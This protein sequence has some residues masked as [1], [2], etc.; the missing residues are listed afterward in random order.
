MWLKV[1]GM[2]LER[3]IELKLCCPE[4]DPLRTRMHLGPCLYF[5]R[6]ARL[7]D[8]R[9]TLSAKTFWDHQALSSHELNGEAEAQR[10]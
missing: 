6:P 7:T 10:P 4:N 2:R 9:V 5:P 1:A 3:K 8:P